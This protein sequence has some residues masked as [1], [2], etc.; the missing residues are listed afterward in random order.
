ML[1]SLPI[2]A[3]TA[4]EVQQLSWQVVDQWLSGSASTIAG[5]FANKAVQINVTSRSLGKLKGGPSKGPLIVYLGKGGAM[6]TWTSN[7]RTVGTGRWEIKSM[8]LGVEIPCFYFDGPK[9]RS[10][11]FFGGTANYVQAATGNVFGLEAGAAVPAK[12]SGKASIASLS[13]KLGL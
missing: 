5:R 2:A 6:L 1:G 13:A 10:E 11:C 7:A 9:G 12:L 3:A 8:G 4:A